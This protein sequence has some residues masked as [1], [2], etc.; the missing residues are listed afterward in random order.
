PAPPSEA[1]LEV[2][3]EVQVAG[4]DTRCLW[5]MQEDAIPQPAVLTAPPVSQVGW[6]WSAEHGEEAIMGS[7][8]HAWLERIGKEG[9]DAW[10]LTR[11]E[12]SRDMLRRQLSRAGLRGESLADGEQ[13]V[14][15]TVAATLTSE[16][17]RW[18]LQAARAYREW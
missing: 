15:E 5:R 7:V 14:F 1:E 16:R 8:A 11:L 17:G 2:A 10:P 6:Q 12:Q 13:A 9:L 3:D 18:L 4:P